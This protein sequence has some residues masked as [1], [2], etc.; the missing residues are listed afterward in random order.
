MKLTENDLRV[1]N[2]LKEN[3]KMRYSDLQNRLDIS[4]AGLT[5]LLNKLLSLNLI[6]REV[7]TDRTTYYSLT[8]EGLKIIGKDFMETLTL[9]SPI[10]DDE[11]RREL[12]SFIKKL[13]QKYGL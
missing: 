3:K 8:E 2:L 7:E 6:K 4:P 5:K 11:E 1:I 9:Y 12:E 10:L 13:K